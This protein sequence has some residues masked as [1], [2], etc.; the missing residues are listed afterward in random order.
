MATQTAVTGEGIRPSHSP[1]MCP[2][3]RASDFVFLRG[4]TGKDATGKI[5]SEDPG[6][7]TRQILTNI[8]NML[9][10]AGGSLQDVVSATIYLMY[11]EDFDAFN[12]V[13]SEFFRDCVPGPARCTIVAQLSGIAR[14][15]I[16]CTAYM[17]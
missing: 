7:Q 13:W 17:K 12:A 8:S 10:A 1:G 16:Q 15:E 5:V 3:V 2:A 4:E 9:H 14:V 11:D 6:E